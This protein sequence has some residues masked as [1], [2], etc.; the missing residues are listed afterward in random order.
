[1]L[2]GERSDVM[3]RAYV[4]AMRVGFRDDT[5]EL[6]HF[7]VDTVRAEMTARHGRLA[8][9]A[10]SA[11]Q[12]PSRPPVSVE[13]AAELLGAEADALMSVRRAK[14]STPDAISSNLPPSPEPPPRTSRMPMTAPVSRDT[15]MLSGQRPTS[16]GQ[17]TLSPEERFIARNSFSDPNMSDEAKE[18]LYASQKARLQ[19]MRRDGLY[20]ERERG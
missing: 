6:D 7:L 1:M 13:R 14:E 8:E 2:N 18:R 10:R 12:P 4:E 11:M 15:P 20:P 3:A 9:A 17:V 5:P 16:H 19:Q